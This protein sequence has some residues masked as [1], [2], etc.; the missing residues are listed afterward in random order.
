MTNIITNIKNILLIILLAGILAIS[1]LVAYSYKTISNTISNDFKSFITVAEK[2]EEL[3]LG[4]LRNL[5][6]MN[7]GA[8]VLETVTITKSVIPQ[9]TTTH[10]CHYK[11]EVTH[12][13]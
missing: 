6:S 7:K 3:K 13:N 12:Y 8:F 11:V 4:V 2:Q 10:K 5:C 1:G 9:V